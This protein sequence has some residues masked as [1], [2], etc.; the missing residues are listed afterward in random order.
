METTSISARKS[1]NL[2]PVAII[3]RIFKSA[4]QLPLQGVGGLSLLA[5]ATVIASGLGL[6]SVAA[7]AALAAIVSL[8]NQI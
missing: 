1:R 8:K 5:A 4:L 7:I 6:D 2:P 3:A